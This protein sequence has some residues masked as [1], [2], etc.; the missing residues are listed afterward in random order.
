LTP[1]RG[2][3]INSQIKLKSKFIVLRRELGL[4]WSFRIKKT[5]A[6]KLQDEYA[7][8]VEGLQE[9]ASD[10]DAFTS[11]PGQ[12]EH[13]LVLQTW[14][15]R[16]TVLPE[17]LLKEAVPGNIRKAEHFVAFLKRLVEYLKVGFYSFH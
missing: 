11:N 5:D 2:A 6:S 10:E 7:K 3:W 1:P 12:P 13:C 9:A 14:L 16:D 15:I 8:L 4:L 17:D